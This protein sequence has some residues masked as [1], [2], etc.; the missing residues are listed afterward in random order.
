MSLFVSLQSFWCTFFFVPIVIRL[1]R[2]H[3][4]GV[5][6]FL[7]IENYIQQGV[8]FASLVPSP[9]KASSLGRETTLA[10]P[11]RSKW[12][13]LALCSSCIFVI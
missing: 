10:L 6:T 1:R 2:H 4:S 13:L 11:V 9:Y 8:S 5:H 3:I 12:R 7:F